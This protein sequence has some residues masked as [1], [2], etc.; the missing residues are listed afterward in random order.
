MDEIEID[1]SGNMATQIDT[2]M[3]DIAPHAS[4][5]RG[6]SP[7]QATE[8]KRNKT[9]EQDAEDERRRRRHAEAE[10]EKKLSMPWLYETEKPVSEPPD[11]NY[12]KIILDDQERIDLL[13]AKKKQAEKPLHYL[14]FKERCAI[15]QESD[16]WVEWKVLREYRGWVNHMLGNA[17]QNRDTK[18]FDFFADLKDVVDDHFQELDAEDNVAHHEILVCKHT[19]RL[20]EKGPDQFYSMFGGAS[21][22]YYDPEDSQWRPEPSQGGQ[23]YEQR[24]LQ[25]QE[26]ALSAPEQRYYDSVQNQFY[27]FD[28]TKQQWFG[29]G[30]IYSEGD[31][32]SF[33]FDEDRQQWI[34]DD[35]HR[36][37]IKGQRDRMLAS[38]AR[39]KAA[40]TRKQHED[41]TAQNHKSGGRSTT[42]NDATSPAS[43]MDIQAEVDAQLA[44]DSN[45]LAEA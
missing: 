18:R 30:T 44:A 17:V 23:L 5:K 1:S 10:E 31:A 39:S 27:V 43:N 21:W 32:S 45:R 7:V 37:G 29:E 16:I 20:K 3:A 36:K 2:I 25:W 13:L 4:E 14:H 41:K 8:A 28:K 38:T 24:K 11:I 35:I 19:R 33:R 42:N 12:R 22:Y 40:Q 9:D 34:P 26:R 15:Y 6:G